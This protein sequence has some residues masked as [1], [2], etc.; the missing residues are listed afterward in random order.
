MTL[1]ACGVTD[2]GRVRRVNQDAH[3]I[4]DVGPT[5]LLALVAD[6]LGGHKAGEV[7][8]ALAVDEFRHQ[9]ESGNFALATHRRLQG[10]MLNIVARRAHAA[11]GE[12]SRRDASHMGMGTT[13]T[14][15]LIEPAGGV[16]LQVGDSRCYLWRDGT[17]KQLSTDQ[18]IAR[19]LLDSGRISKQQFAT[20]PDRNR[21]SQCLGLEDVFNPLEPAVVPFDWSPGQRLLLCSDGLTDMVDDA[22]I[23]RLM[24]IA[25]LQ[26]AAQALVEAAL[27]AGGR[28]NVTTVLVAN[29]DAAQPQR[30][31]GAGKTSFFSFWRSAALDRLR[32]RT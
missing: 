25:P 22:A 18:T 6:G 32:R 15:V 8:S 26:E 19:Q 5:R 28:D 24:A 27:E 16:F 4:A 9:V 23:S 14:A 17:V 12:A 31:S 3:Y 29:E 11:I 7:A 30:R 10:D 21:L 20:H 2:V 13:L 1:H